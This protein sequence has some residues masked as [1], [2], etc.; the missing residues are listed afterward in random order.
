VT[1]HG[2]RRR[3]GSGHDR[4]RAGVGV[5][6][7]RPAPVGGHALRVEGAIVAVAALHRV[8]TPRMPAHLSF[9]ASAVTAG[10]VV[11]LAHAGGATPT[12]MGMGRDRLREGVKVGAA[13]SLIAVASIGG[14]AL[15]PWARNL[16]VGGRSPT[17]DGESALYAAA[18]R[19]PV[20]TALVEETI[21]RGALFGLLL[22]RLSPAATT[23]ASS[24][25][26]GAWHIVPALEFSR[27]EVGQNL[28]DTWVS[29]AANLVATTAA[30]HLFA[31]LRL[32]TGSLLA[33][34]LA[35]TATNVTAYLASAGDSVP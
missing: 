19:I 23:A 18:L 5:R 12:D 11:A 15:A 7:G 32:R 33:P 3:K 4:P 17:L 34:F 29:V 14:V 30:G 22:R 21:F 6:G 27:T 10:G 31:R 35:H 28:G 26:F 24:V 1:G 9:P 8:V 16:A 25:L 20:G 2:W 13:A